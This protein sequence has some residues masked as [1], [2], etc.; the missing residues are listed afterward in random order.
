MA[1]W[2]V[3]VHPI[4]QGMSPGFSEASGGWGSG[5]NG[6]ASPQ[7]RLA[8]HSSSHIPSP[9][10]ECGPGPSSRM[11]GLTARRPAHQRLLRK[12]ALFHSP[13][14]YHRRGVGGQLRAGEKLSVLC[15]LGRS[16][17]ASPGS[18]VF[19]FSPVRSSYDLFCGLLK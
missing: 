16:H 3:T 9:G 14:A 1:E 13:T 17:Q 19:S 2:P 18:W 6:T 12:R 5:C 15:H 8:M 7:S 11:D 10:W 4:A